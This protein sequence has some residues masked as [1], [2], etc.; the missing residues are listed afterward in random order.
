MI[1]APP[2]SL[3]EAA[4]A[5]RQRLL[6]RLSG[7]LRISFWAPSLEVFRTFATMPPDM[8]ATGA[9]GHNWGLTRCENRHLSTVQEAIQ[10]VFGHGIARLKALIVDA[11]TT[12][13]CFPRIKPTPSKGGA[14]D[15]LH[16][17]RSNIRRKMFW[18]LMPATIGIWIVPKTRKPP[19]RM[20]TG[21]RRRYRAYFSSS[22]LKQIE[23]VADRRPVRWHVW[24]VR[25]RCRVGEI[26]PAPRRNRIKAPVT[27]DEL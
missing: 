27:F 18:A 13:V 7:S 6:R 26:I 16:T 21:H 17:R 20:I 25:Q 4:E 9:R 19:G 14:G 1:S 10:K 8:F 22:E 3:A 11:F 24:V 12:F 23:Q 5:L 2:S 15:S